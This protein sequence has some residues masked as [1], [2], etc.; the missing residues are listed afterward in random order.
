MASVSLDIRAN[1]QKVLGEFKKLS[2]ELDNKFLVQGLKLDVVK[3]AFRD[4]TKEFNSALSDQGFKTTE[5]TNQLQRGV[6][7]NLAVLNKLSIDAAN[8]VSKQIRSNLEQLQAQAQVTGETV[9]ETLTAAGFFEFG[10]SEEQIQQQF[11][12]FS[13]RFAKFA[14]QT[15]DVFGESSAG[16]LQ[17]VITG[18]ADVETLFGL[19]FGAGGAGTN[20][21]ISELRK[22]AGGN[23]R[24]LSAETR[25]EIINQLLLDAEDASTE[26]GKFFQQQV[27]SARTDDPFR[28]I[29]REI[30]SLFSPR[31][32]FGV[33]RT[34]GGET[35]KIGAFGDP[36][37]LVDRNILQI[38]SKL[39]Q[40]IFDK[41][42]GLFA[43]LNNTLKEVF[44]DFDVLEPIASGAELLTR[45]LENLGEFFQSDTFKNF[46]GIFKPIKESIDGLLEDNKID[47]SEINNI[48]SSV[49]DAIRSIMDNIAEFIRNID[50]SQLG[51]ILGNI[52]DEIVK[53][54]PSLIGLIFSSIGKLAETA[55]SGFSSASGGTKGVLG[56]ALGLFTGLK[57]ADFASN[58]IS[59]RREGGGV[60]GAVNRKV[61]DAGRRTLTRLPGLRRFAERSRGSEDRD[62][63]GGYEGYQGQVIRRLTQI[64]EILRDSVPVYIKRPTE[65]FPRQTYG[66]YG[67]RRP[68]NTTIQ[69]VDDEFT[70]LPG[71]MRRRAGRVGSGIRNR[72]RGGLGR[73]GGMRSRIG[74]MLGGGIDLADDILGLTL[75]EDDFIQ[76]GYSNP[77][78]PLPME[79]D[80]PWAEVSEGQYKPYKPSRSRD[81]V[82]A[83][84]NRRFGVRGRMASFGRG[85]K[86]IAGRAGGGL[87]GGALTALT[88][89]SILGGGDAN[90]SEMEGMSSEEKEQF[91]AERRK[92]AREEA[93]GALVGAAGG[94]LGGALGSF[95]G[96]AGTII[97]GMLGEMAGSALASAPFMAPINEGIG[98][99][100]EDIGGW[101]GKKWQEVV[102]FGQQSWSKMGEAWEG[103][104]GFFGEE[105]P[106]Q[107]S[108]RWVGDVKDKVGG[109]MQTGWNEFVDNIKSIPG[110]I[111][112]GT[113]DLLPWTG[114]NGRSLGGAGTGWTLVGENGPEMA[115]LGTGSVVYPQSSWAGMGI[116]KGGFS[117]REVTNNITININAPGAELFADELT[118]TL[119]SRLDELFETQSLT[120][121]V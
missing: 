87:L 19:D 77:I 44:G 94:A 102:G 96:P 116:G 18:Q 113:R 84:Y 121:R 23:I 104:T 34:I 70:S 82:R 33:L 90:A 9:K 99:L 16:Q 83:R 39:L 26:F 37:N 111:W 5:T 43:I 100:A 110:N 20:L 105:G 52:L 93:G 14:Q 17:K 117:Q 68:P 108:W 45:G 85:L 119:V 8:Q 98:K 6:A 65:Q 81:A 73:L 71:R 61:R 2:R 15:K 103:I 22:R 109:W 51:S 79:S 42:E 40:T 97:G 101:L 60:L 30:Q 64:L 12:S 112:Q 59:R 56:T 3:N 31:G 54:L 38:T 95:F 36:E 89:G 69:D 91:R 88:I 11:K 57:V 48:I 80:E 67:P 28:Y 72:V 29:Q 118:S 58:V 27:S 62:L 53:T 25:T 47:T 86:G 24:S 46:L 49:F 75:G 115:N 55:I 41:E 1:T 106:I 114:K 78:G 35:A 74:A 4:I 92:S 32:V 120:T 63:T 50:S 107:K 7:A 13:D 76:D 66:E 21:I 10:G